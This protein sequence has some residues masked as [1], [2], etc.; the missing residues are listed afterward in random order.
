MNINVKLAYDNLK[1][2]RHDTMVTFG[3]A[4]FIFIALISI[5]NISYIY[6][7]AV[8]QKQLKESGKWVYY[9]DSI[10]LEQYHQI[11]K[12]SD[13]TATVENVGIAQYDQAYNVVSL[14]ENFNN[15]VGPIVIDGTYP[16]EGELALSKMLLCKLGYE[17]KTG[18][19]INLDYQDHNGNMV[20]FQ[21]KLSGIVTQET[22]TF[23]H[24]GLI[25]DL[26][27]VIL[28]PREPNSEL[29]SVFVYD[30]ELIEA[31]GNDNYYDVLAAK[32]EDYHL[33]NDIRTNS[34]Y[35]LQAMEQFSDNLYFLGAFVIAVL[36]SFML[37]LSTTLSSL[38]RRLRDFTLLR[39]IGQTKR[40]ML[41]MLLAQLAMVVLIGAVIGI[42][43]ALLITYLGFIL[44]KELVSENV[45]FIINI[46]TTLWMVVVGVS[47]IFLGMFIPS[48]QSSKKALSGTFDEMSFKRFSIRYRKLKYQNMF[49]LAK[50]EFFRNIKLNLILIII[51]SF[52]F[53]PL[54]T[55]LSIKSQPDEIIDNDLESNIIEVTGTGL[56]YEQIHELEQLGDQVHYFN[57]NCDDNEGYKWSNNQESYYFKNNEYPNDIVY[58]ESFSYYSFASNSS[59]YQDLSEM[60]EG[61]MPENDHE[62]IAYLPYYQIDEFWLTASD[63][64]NEYEDTIG[65][66]S[67]ISV[68][69]Q[70][71]DDEYNLTGNND[72]TDYQVVG[73]VHKLPYGLKNR[74]D[75]ILLSPVNIILT[76]SEYCRKFDLENNMPKFNQVFINCKD[77]INTLSKVKQFNSD[78]TL[79][80]N[81][82]SKQN[83]LN[84]ELSDEE[85]NELVIR[86]TLRLIIS[87]FLF[88]YLVR[89]RMINNK[90]TIGMLKSLGTTKSQIYRLYVY[91][92]LMIGAGGTFLA[93]W[94]ILY[95][96]N[97][98]S[99][100]LSVAISIILLNIVIIII[101]CLPLR[102]ILKQDV[103]RMIKVRE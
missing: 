69:K 74:Y 10:N 34:N 40:Q 22:I 3:L 25:V 5:T 35:R 91:Q 75:D 13:D 90:S 29:I 49:R 52:A 88:T 41:K 89:Y 59:M 81:D 86:N 93:I 46:K 9:Q 26:G 14:S 24:D 2:N 53:T 80:I 71:V 56:T 54:I 66:S 62:I 82:Y 11:E 98:V 38:E 83:Q 84:K 7:N 102:K 78:K 95:S 16:K 45:F 31:N 101:Y 100:N 33:F 1:R 76:E 94:N 73:I 36:I 23:A 44:I 4:V 57:W 61:R 30:R 6:N 60:I 103:I 18:E 8:Y 43:L 68:Y 20:T 77:R 96:Y 39:A 17:G 72:K 48:F 92:A 79:M 70:Y 51:S 67:I 85:G 28:P 32:F 19:V 63:D 37:M 15:L 97:I 21:G 64:S 87:L 99:N 42:T 55:L 65:L 58:G 12:V 47:I 50:R 27:A